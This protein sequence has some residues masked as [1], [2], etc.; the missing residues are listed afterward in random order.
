MI[1]FVSLLFE[2]HYG[3]H[4]QE[5]EGKSGGIGL[6]TDDEEKYSKGIA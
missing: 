2:Q 1:L 6:P 3:L 4:C 5:N